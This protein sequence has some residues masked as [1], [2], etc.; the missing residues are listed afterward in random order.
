[1]SYRKGKP[2]SLATDFT[3]SHGFFFNL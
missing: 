3:N 1:L 2:Q